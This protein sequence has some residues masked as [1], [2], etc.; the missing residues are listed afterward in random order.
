MS[1]ANLAEMFFERADELTTRPR[2]RYRTEDGWHEV[3][4]RAMADGVRAVVT[5]EG[6]PGAGQS[7]AA[8]M[9]RGRVAFGRTLAEIEGRV[10]ALRRDQLATIVYTSGTTGPPKGVLQT[11]GNHLATIE[12]LL[13][14]G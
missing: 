4:W 12:S 14:V 11:H 13:K 8:L 3:T 1:Y 7:L 9:E 5:I 6:D 2:Y 10:A